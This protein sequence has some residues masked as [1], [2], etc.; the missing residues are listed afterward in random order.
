MKDRFS[1]AITAGLIGSLIMSV[2]IEG[3]HLI[4]GISIRMIPEIATLFIGRA[5]STSAA[6]LLT[7]HIAHFICGSFVSIGFL[8]AYEIT[9]YN[10]PLIKGAWM[11]ASA[12]FLLCGV[13]AQIL[14]LQIYDKASDT[15]LLLLTHIA[16]GVTVGW[17][18]SKYRHR[19]KT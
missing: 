1:L 5:A 4:P 15:L 3:L 17:F 13:L 12:W 9:G 7:G 8:A 16:Y 2:L 10:Y 14:G 11:G 19:E 6:G 18:M